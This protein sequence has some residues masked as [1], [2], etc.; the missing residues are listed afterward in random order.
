MIYIIILLVLGF[1]IFLNMYIKLLIISKK[2]FDVS[3]NLQSIL[4]FVD[5][6]TCF[7]FKYLFLKPYFNK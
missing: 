5:K 4:H 6:L 1:D 7:L 3:I 2:P